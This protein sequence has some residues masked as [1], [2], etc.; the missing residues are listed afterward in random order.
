LRKNIVWL[1]SHLLLYLPTVQVANK[2][3]R[4]I[5]LEVGI[6]QITKTDFV[7]INRKGVA[8]FSYPPDAVSGNTVFE[9]VH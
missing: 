8:L 3:T 6:Q 5:A 9:Y 4:P 2:G 1:V 7:M